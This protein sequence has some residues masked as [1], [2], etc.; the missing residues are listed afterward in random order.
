MTNIENNPCS[1]ASSLAPKQNYM[2]KV[3]VGLFILSFILNSCFTWYVVRITWKAN[4]KYYHKT[5]SSLEQI[6]NVQII[7]EKVIPAIQK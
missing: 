3:I 4:S 6:H 2:L 5:I 1:C 7:D